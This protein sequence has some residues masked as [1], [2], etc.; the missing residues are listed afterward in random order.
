MTASLVDRRKEEWPDNGFTLCDPVPL[1]A[2]LH[3]EMI[4]EFV[5]HKA[6]V[7]TGGSLTRGKYTS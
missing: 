2:A 3:P 5:V 7:E 6:S 1:S 4:E